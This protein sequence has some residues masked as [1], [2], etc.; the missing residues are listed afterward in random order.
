M[1]QLLDQFGR[2]QSHTTGTLS[3]KSKNR[4]HWIGKIRLRKG[5]RLYLAWTLVLL[6]AVYTIEFIAHSSLFLVITFPKR[7]YS[8]IAKTFDIQNPVIGLIVKLI[9]DSTIFSTVTISGTMLYC[10]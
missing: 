7:M 2:D 10:N 6:H 3:S 8:S 9:L 4:V 5:Y 1:W